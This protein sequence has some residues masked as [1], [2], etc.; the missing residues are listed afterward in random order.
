MSKSATAR[1]PPSFA[2]LVQSFFT[3]HLIQQRA[4][5]PRT[6]ATYRDGF[7]LFLD[8]ATA[9]LHQQPTTM[10][11]QDITPALVL[12]FLD[13]LEHDRGN[14]VRTR[15]AR[16]AA[17]R[18]FLKFAG[19][20]DVD[21]LHVV[22]QAL[23]VPMKRFERPMLGFLTRE[24]MLAIIGKPGAS[25]TRQRDHLLLHM[26]YNTGARVSEIIGVRLADV[27][28]DGAACVH[29][30]GKG[31]KQRTMPLWRSTV[32]AVRAWLRFNPN[33]LSE[34]PLLPNRYGHLM[35]RTNVAQRLALALA[36]ATADMPSLRD[37]HISPHTIRHTTAMHLLQ[38]G[39]PIDGIAL[40]LGHESPTTTHQY[41]E[42]NLAMKEK[43][44]ARIQD[45]DTAS[46]RFRASDSLL[47]F[48]KEL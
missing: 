27:V 9:H 35:T 47:E 3:E 29:L 31:R 7:V 10:K 15:N 4:M 11:L 41:I 13:H 48:L 18:A 17:L 2:A 19:H 33:L 45:P 6:V 26:L 20:R 28:L 16:L 39:E 24:E 25:W 44:L 14:T 5:S 37:R 8:F 38:S 34:S 43:A 36:A 1:T 12:A 42:A 30:H 21:A 46:R 32:Q 23:G 22:E 40:W